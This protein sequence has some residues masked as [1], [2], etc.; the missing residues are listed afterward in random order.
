MD[1]VV[2]R[3]LDD[4]E[5]SS[6]QCSN[7]NFPTWLRNDRRR[8]CLDLR[9]FEVAKERLLHTMAVCQRPLCTVTL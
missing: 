6:Q 4:A 3:S 5:L 7:T 2:F 9:V 8:F 1:L